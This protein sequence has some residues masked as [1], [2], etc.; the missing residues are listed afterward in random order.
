MGSLLLLHTLHLCQPAAGV[1][2]GELFVCSGQLLAERAHGSQVFLGPLQLDDVAQQAVGEGKFSL[3]HPPDLLQGHI[4][5]A[6]QLDL[7]QGL[8]ILLTIIPVAV[9]CVSTGGEQ[10]LLFIEADIPL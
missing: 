5:L 7:A 1:Q 4:Q 3:L 8:H 2:V 10:S 6:Q 9:V